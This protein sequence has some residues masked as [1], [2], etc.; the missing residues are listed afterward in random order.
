MGRM[1]RHSADDTGYRADS[2]LDAVTRRLIELKIDKKK[3][4]T[5]TDKTQKYIIIGK[6]RCIMLRKDLWAYGRGDES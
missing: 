1:M 5:H 4:E 2:A 3:K 6:G